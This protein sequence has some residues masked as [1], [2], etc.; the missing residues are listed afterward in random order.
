MAGVYKSLQTVTGLTASEN[1]R[2]FCYVMTVIFSGGAYVISVCC[3]DAMLA[4]LGLSWKPRAR[5]SP[6]ASRSGLSPR[7]MRAR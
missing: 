3:I 4:L 1:P 7:P 5:C 2:L 6:G